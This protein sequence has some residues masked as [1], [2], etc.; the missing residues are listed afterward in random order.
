[1]NISKTNRLKKRERL[2]RQRDIEEL[3]A[4]NLSFN[5]YPIRAI[6][7]TQKSISKFGYQVMFVVPKRKFRRAVDRNYIRRRMR[8]AY[9]L[10]KDI[11]NVPNQN[12]LIAFLYHG[13]KAES[14]SE[15]EQKIILTLLRLKKYLIS[16]KLCN[17]K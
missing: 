6:I 16:E 12:I 13:V 3:F 8:E 1:M 7:S 17:E 4:S 14:F 11:L 15:M 2:C 10:N 9:R 5:E